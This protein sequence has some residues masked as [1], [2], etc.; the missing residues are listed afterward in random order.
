MLLSIVAA[1][2]WTVLRWNNGS[3]SAADPWSAIPAQAAVIVEVPDAWAH[4]DRFAHTSLLWSAWE[5]QPGTLALSRLMTRSAHA[6]EKDAMLLKAL[7][8]S[9][10]L[11]ALMRN[12]SRVRGSLQWAPSTVNHPPMHWVIYSALRLRSV[13]CL[14]PGR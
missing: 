12:G 2:A 14:P 5:K 7:G 10:V 6:M 4:W 13:R 8:G 1:A 11:V 3:S 9:T